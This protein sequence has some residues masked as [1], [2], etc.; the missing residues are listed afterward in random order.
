MMQSPSSSIA[1][2][3]VSRNC[4]RAI[5]GRTG[6]DAAVLGELKF[7]PT[8]AGELKLSP[9]APGELKL[10][11]TLVGE[12]FSPPGVGGAHLEGNDPPASAPGIEGCIGRPGMTSLVR[13]VSSGAGPL[14]RA[15]C[16]PRRTSSWISDCSLN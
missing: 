11:P 5:I 14:P 10:S 9:T 3:K 7:A 6:D 12:D 4:P 15:S 8:S 13:S 16:K 1:M 2:M